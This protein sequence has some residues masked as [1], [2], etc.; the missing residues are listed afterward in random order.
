MA[1]RRLV[2]QLA[3]PSRAAGPRSVTRIDRHSLVLI[4]GLLTLVALAG[5]LYLS[6]AS[7]AAELRYRLADAEGQT[8]HLWAQNLALKQEIADLGRLS[9]VEQRVA[10]LGMVEAPSNGPYIA[11]TVPQTGPA[12]ASPEAAGAPTA[13]DEPAGS[14]WEL[15]ARSLGWISRPNELATARVEHP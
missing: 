3:Y 12:L 14:P 15:V 13:A 4:L 11:C 2:A 9:A 10:R 6:Q 7:V 1:S 8:Q 5:V